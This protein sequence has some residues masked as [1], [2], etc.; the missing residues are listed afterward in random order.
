M[1]STT[2]SRPGALANNTALPRSATAR[3]SRPVHRSSAGTR[4][5]SPAPSWAEISV[6]V[7]MDRLSIP[8]ARRVTVRIF[9]VAVSL[10]AML[11]LAPLLALLTLA[12]A[13]TSAGAPI[14]VHQ[15][16]GRWGE[17]F[18]CLKF[19]SMYAD[20]DARLDIVLDSE[21]TLR[22]EWEQTFKLKKDPRVTFIGRVI[23]R[24]NLDELP[25]LVNVLL[26][27]MS[28]VGPRP[29][30]TAEA[31]RYGNKLPAVLSVRPG[32]TGLWQTSGRSNTSYDDRTNL[33]L[34]YVVNQSL[35]RDLE[36]C[37]RTAHQM[38]SPHSN[39]AC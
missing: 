9:D 2:R 26:G 23:R 21:P 38:F 32:L 5:S 28:I 12:I 22:T 4:H 39:G 36:I 19:R 35:R 27:Q 20:A 6:H 29:I 7:W 3:G 33:D 13:C 18:P 24:T 17:S 10:T 8:V 1:T 16:L 11:A 37:V 25:Q 15:R 14:Y 31:A 34:E 30:V